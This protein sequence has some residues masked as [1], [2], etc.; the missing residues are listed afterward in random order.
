ML[1]SPYVRHLPPGEHME[2]MDIQS[3]PV[4]TFALFLLNLLLLIAWTICTAVGLGRLRR[5]PLS[6]AQHVLWTALVLFVPFFGS[7]AVLLRT[8]ATSKLS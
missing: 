6:E 1:Q 8:S 2:R 4:T 5:L 3:L 7:A